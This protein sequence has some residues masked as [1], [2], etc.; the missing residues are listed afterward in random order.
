MQKVSNCCGADI[1][2]EDIDICPAC[3]E[4]CEFETLV[5][6][7]YDLANII[8]DDELPTPSTTENK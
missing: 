1:V 4:H 2:D 5:E 7:N 8:N 3:G 6:D